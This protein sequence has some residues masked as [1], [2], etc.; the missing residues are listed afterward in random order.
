MKEKIVEV[1]KLSFS[2]GENKVLDDVSFYFERGDFI[3]IIGPNGSA[4]STLLKL[5]LGILKA[6][7]GSIKLFGK[8]IEKFDDWKKVGYISQN[9]REFNTKFPATVEEIVG[10]N[11]YSSMGLFKKL[12]DELKG[13]IQHALSIVDMNEHKDELVGNLSG[14]QKQRVFIAR[15]LVNRPEIL[16]MDEPLI[17]VDIDSQNKFYNLM[18][19]LNKEYGMTLVMVSHDIG[20]ITNKV[21]KILCLSNRNICIHYP[22]NLK[23]GFYKEVFG[24]DMNII[25]HEH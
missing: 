14:G 13:R 9:V 3:G 15:A 22:E 12:N 16:F 7:E 25:I 8:D 6:K 24:G 5:M 18:E 10:A 23:E 11:L 4:K 19:R 2:Y 1:D 20:V 17:G 21:N